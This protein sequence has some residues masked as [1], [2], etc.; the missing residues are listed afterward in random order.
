MQKTLEEARRGKVIGHSLDAVVTLAAKGKEKD[1]LAKYADQLSDIFIVSRV[2]L[3][4]TAPA[5][6]TASETVPGL[7][8]AVAKAAGAKCPRCWNYTED[9]GADAAHPEVC[10]SCAA[11]FE[12]LKGL[13]AE[14]P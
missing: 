14:G 8:V 1:L 10:G 6:A 4:D 2:V 7:S 3:T 13:R 5:G 11:K 9:I 12:R